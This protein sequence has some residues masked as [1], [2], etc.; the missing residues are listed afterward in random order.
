MGECHVLNS[1]LTSGELPHRF[2]SGNGVR[3]GRVFAPRE[4]VREKS[5]EVTVARAKGRN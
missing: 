1:G 2:R 4:P 5:F 3:V